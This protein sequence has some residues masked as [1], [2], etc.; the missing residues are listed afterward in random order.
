MS[1]VHKFTMALGHFN[2]FFLGLGRGVAWVSLS[3]MLIIVVAHVFFRTFFDALTWSHEATRFC[4]LWMAGLAAPSAF[5][6]GG[7]V[8]IEMI[9]DYLPRRMATALN[10]MLLAFAL[11]IL[12]YGLQLSHKHVATG[13]IWNSGSLKVPMS[14]IGM[15]S[16]ALKQAWMYLSML[17]FMYCMI[18]VNI[19]LLLR[20]V[21]NFFDPAT[22][23][24]PITAETN[25]G[26]D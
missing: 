13:W 16:F 14:L 1:I 9:R 8:S 6:A 4:M 2:A 5:R 26:V 24:Y 11:I 22:T 3:L 10:F 17:V 7:F 23:T 15:K 25:V 19:E 12:L 21:L 20:T 18:A